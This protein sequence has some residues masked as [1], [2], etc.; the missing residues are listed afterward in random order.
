MRSNPP[1]PPTHREHLLAL[2]AALWRTRAWWQPLPFRDPRPGWT[3]EAPALV[4]ALLGLRDAD[5][6]RLEADA[7]ALAAFLMAWVPGL[8]EV[9][10]LERCEGEVDDGPERIEA[11]H[12][13]SGDRADRDIPGRKLRQVRAFGASVL[14][15]A[16]GGVVPAMGDTMRHV[17]WCAGKG[18]LGRWVAR[19]TSGH[20]T[21]LERDPAL[22][23]AG[24]AL[25]ARAAP[26]RQQFVAVDVL[27]RSQAT[28]V[29]AMVD[30]AHVL[31]LHACGDTHRRLVE[32]SGRAR[33]IDLVPCCHHKTA[34]LPRASVEPRA[35]LRLGRDDLRLAV[36]GTVTSAPRERR[37][38]RRRREFTL[39][40]VALR[41]SVLPGSIAHPLPS[42]PAAW[43][44]EPFE[45]F[46]RLAAARLGIALPTSCDFAGFERQGRE[47]L[48]E[49]ERLSLVRHAF[50]R[51]I[52]MWLVLDL[53]VA[54]EEAGHRC[55]IVAFCARPVTP[56]NLLIRAWRAPDPSDDDAQAV[57][58]SPA[59][60][61]VAGDADAPAAQSRAASAAS[62]TSAGPR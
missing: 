61:P 4:A 24:E 60:S 52:E 32:L 47:R 38:A 13:P 12:D 27:G 14:G 26:G 6:D 56:R 46:A 3:V 59:R 53:A 41:E 18:H 1:D 49:V 44:R 15:A 21:S 2:D 20:V 57:L 8:A 34:L 10:R 39:G 37:A 19:R 9:K 42:L 25:A 48:H 35:R 55:R 33:R 7:P 22:C 54:M 31:A 30:G 43:S 23:A 36:T 58:D 51:A 62:R 50:R 16:D 45:T 28:G 5:V 29:A 17:E 11:G 40:L